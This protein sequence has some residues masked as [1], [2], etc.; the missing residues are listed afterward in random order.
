[1]ADSDPEN[2]IGEI[3]IRDVESRVQGLAREVRGFRSSLEDLKHRMQLQNK[4]TLFVRW[5]RS[6]H[7]RFTHNKTTP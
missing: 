3:K 7:R 6:G 2:K 4:P 5:M 1:M